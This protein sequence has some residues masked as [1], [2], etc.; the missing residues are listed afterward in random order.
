[1]FKLCNEKNVHY[2]FITLQIERNLKN[3]AGS[4]SIKNKIKPYTTFK[5]L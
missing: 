5:Y 3:S 2:K 4:N 1:M